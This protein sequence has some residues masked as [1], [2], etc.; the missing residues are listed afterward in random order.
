[1]K[2]QI[3]SLALFMLMISNITKAFG[4]DFEVNGICYDVISFEEMTAGVT[5]KNGLY[6]GEVVIPETVVYNNR[7]FRVMKILSSAFEHCME[8]ISVSL[9]NTI[10]EIHSNAF[11]RNDALVNVNLPTGLTIIGN[12]A[13]SGCSVESFSF[14][15]GLTTIG[16]GAFS[17]CKNIKKINLPNSLVSLGEDAFKGC[18]N[19]EEFN[20]PSNIRFLKRGTFSGC[21]K[22]S[23]ITIPKHVNTLESDAFYQCYGCKKIIFEDSDYSLNISYDTYGHFSAGQ[24]CKFLYLGRSFTWNNSYCKPFESL[25]EIVIG[26]K[27]PIIKEINLKTLKKVTI[28]SS[29]PPSVGDF[30]SFSN[31]QYMDMLLYIPDSSKEIYESAEPWKN[32]WNIIESK[33]DVDP[34][35]EGG[36]NSIV[37]IQANAVLIQSVNGQ[38]NITGA[39]DGTKVNVYDFN[40]IKIDSTII[41]NGSADLKTN[42]QPGSIAIIKIGERSVK[43]VIE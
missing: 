31:S 33:Y 2:Q 40:G 39:D 11:S 4:A 10:T 34:K 41:H 12:E 13:F 21:K 38:I 32:F 23:S 6:K 9:P 14:P 20:I 18:T 36:N 37:Q 25:E 30:L 27:V 28:K 22:I 5:Y 24:Y 26:E 3:I 42:L 7:S 8:L 19:L 15:E 17:Y 43:V 35:T 16:K 1:M 29:L